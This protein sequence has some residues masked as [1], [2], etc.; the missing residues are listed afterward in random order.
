MSLLTSAV[1]GL[2]DKGE[3]PSHLNAETRNRLA[4]LLVRAEP[5]A[6]A[7]VRKYSTAWALDE[8]IR[9][10]VRAWSALAA[11]ETVRHLRAPGASLATLAVA[12]ISAGTA[13][14]VTTLLLIP[15]VGALAGALLAASGV[16]VSLLGM[17]LATRYAG[18]IAQHRAAIPPFRV[19]LQEELERQAITALDR[20]RDRLAGPRRPI[21]KHAFPELLPGNAQNL[22]AAWMRHLGELDATVLRPE[23]TVEKAPSLLPEQAHLISSG[24]IGR[25]W[26]F[27]AETPDLE[28]GTLEDAARATGKRPL[29]FSLSGFPEPVIVRANSHGVGLLTFEPWNGTLA[30]HGTYGDRYL[31]R[32]L[33]DVDGRAG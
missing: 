31:R 15:T 24:Y 1:P 5:L 22:A 25:V 13:N 18:I 8:N 11:L 23:E 28:L 4:A 32:G 3:E 12:V 14:L 29:L 17:Q 21:P 9:R 10:D 27:T 16:L 33:R 20:R 6:A 7:W 26:S 19:Q 2:L 30:G